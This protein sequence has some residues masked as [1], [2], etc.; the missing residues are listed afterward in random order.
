YGVGLTI[1]KRLCD[2][3]DWPLDIQS[4]PGTGTRV[5]VTF[6]QARYKET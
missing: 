5:T 1:V 4:T 3:F 6:P 2:R